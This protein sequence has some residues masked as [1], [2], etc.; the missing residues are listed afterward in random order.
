M[1]R[2]FPS[3]ADAANL[4][5]WLNGTHL[6]ICIHDGDKDGFIRYRSSNIIGIDTAIG[7]YG[8]VGGFEAETFQVL[9]GMQYGMVFY[10]RGNQMVA[11]FLRGKR[12]P[13][14]GKIITFRTAACKSDLCWTTAKDFSYLL[15]G[16][17]DSLH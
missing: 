1:K 5:N 8:Y 10:R 6:V 17:I 15:S 4:A 12:H 7:I 13:F 16:T 11:L 2:Y 3:T 14:N 9:T